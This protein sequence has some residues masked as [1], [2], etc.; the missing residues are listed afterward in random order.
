MGPDAFILGVL[1]LSFKLFHSPLS[2]WPSLKAQL[3]KNP[4]A[5]QDT[6]VLF[7][8]SKIHWRRD[9][10]PTSVLLGFPCCSAGKESTC[11]AGGLGSIP[12]L[13]RSPGEGKG[14]QY[15]D[16]ENF[17]GC[18]PQG[19]KESDTTEQLALSPSSRGS[20]IP[21]HILLFEWLS[22][23]YLKLRMFLPV[24]LISACD[25]SS[26]AFHMNYSAYMLLKI[27]VTVYSVVLI[28]SCQPV[29][30]F[31][32]GPNCCFLTFIQVSQKTGKVIWL[33]LPCLRIFHN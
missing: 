32:Y 26:L 27:K 4:P 20:F 8:C 14:F 24:I 16:L 33:V 7:L 29:S 11:N 10:R 18:S 5:M 6:L 23:A 28:F 12:G 9:R 25:I 22:S 30:C 31:I 3:V 19:Y 15:S 17:M 2:P 21:L 1:M 13:G